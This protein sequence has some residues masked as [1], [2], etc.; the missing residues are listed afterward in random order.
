MHYKYI[1]ELHACSPEEIDSP[2][3]VLVTSFCALPLVDMADRETA[4]GRSPESREK[5]AEEM[6]KDDEEEELFEVERVIGKSKIKVSI[7]L[8]KIWGI[9]LLENVH[10]FLF[11]LGQ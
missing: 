5:E 4:A 10:L 8:S 9:F 6:E 11:D 1:F 2:I 3:S 7:F